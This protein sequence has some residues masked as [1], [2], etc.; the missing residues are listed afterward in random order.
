MIPDAALANLV[1]VFAWVFMAIGFSTQAQN[2][3]FLSNSIQWVN[4]GDVDVSGNQMTI[5]AKVYSNNPA[6]VN[7][8]SKHTDP[9]NANYL[10]RMG[11]FEV[12]TTNGFVAVG[13]TVPVSTNNCYHLAAT[14]DGSF[15]RYYVNGCETAAVPWSGNLLNNNLATAIGNM[16][17]CQCEQ[18]YGY[19]DE[20][21]IWN[22]ARTQTEIES[23]MDNLPNPTLQPGLRAYYSFEGNYVNLQGNAAFNGTPVGAVS[24]AINP[25]CPLT[26]A[27]FAVNANASNVV[28]GTGGSITIT[29]TGG[30]PPYTYSIDGVNFQGNPVFSNLPGGTYTATARSANGCVR[31]MQVIIA[32]PGPIVINGATTDVACNGAAIGTIN[33][34]VSGGTAPYTPVWNSPLASGLN[35][36]GLSA[37]AYNVTITDAQGC[38]Q[39]QSFTINQPGPLSTVLANVQQITCFGLSDGAATA[40][41]AGGTLPYSYLWTN[42]ESTATATALSV[43]THSATITDGN[44]CTVNSSNITISQPLPIQPTVSINQ[45]VSCNGLSDGSATVSATGGGLPYTFLWPNGITTATNTTLA[46]GNGTVTVNDANNC[47]ATAAYTIQEPSALSASISVIS[48]VSCNGGSDAVANASA[49]GGI[50]PY[51]FTWS[52][53]FVGQNVSNLSEGINDVSVTDDNGCVA[54]ASTTITEPP[55]LTATIVAISDVSCNGLADG[56]ADVTVNGGTAPYFYVWNNGEQTQQNSTLSAG[57]ITVSVSDINGC[58]ITALGTM[59]E[60]SGLVVNVIVDQNVSCVGLSDGQATA[61]ETGGV[62][63]YSFTWSNGETVSNATQLNAGTHSVLLTDGNGCSVTSAPFIISEPAALT[64]AIQSVS[65]VTCNGLSDGTATMVINGGTGPYQIAWPDGQSSTTGINLSAGNYTVNITDAN[66]CVTSLSV[67]I[68]EPLPMSAT[69]QWLSDISCFGEIDGR[70][71]VTVTGGTPPFTFMWSNGENVQ[72]ATELPSGN[73][74][75]VVFDSYLCNVASNTINIIEPPQL[76]VTTSVLNDASCFGF[77]DGNADATPTGGTP[78]Y[79]FDWSNGSTTNLAD[80]V[81]SGTYTVTVTDNNSCTATADVTIASPPEIDFTV[82]ADATMCI[83]EVLTL[84]ATP[85]P[86][87][88]PLSFNWSNGFTGASQQVSPIVSTTYTV[89]AQNGI[90]TS[91]PTDI[92]ITV[93]PPISVQASS[94]VSVCVGESAE[95]SASASGGSGNLTYT[96]DTNL[97]TGQGP[98]TVAP[99]TTSTYTVTVTDDCGTPAQTAQITVTVNPLPEIDYNADSPN[100]CVPHAVQIQNASTIASG[101]IV[102]HEWN[103]GTQTSADENPQFVFNQAG[104]FDL[105]VT[106]TSDAGCQSTETYVGVVNSYPNPVAAFSV[107]LSVVDIL[108]PTVAVSNQSVGAVNYSWMAETI[109]STEFEPAFSF[110]DT[111]LHTIYLTVSTENGCEDQSSVT[112][113]VEPSFAFY[114][115]DAFTV[116]QDF[117]NEVFSPKFIG[118]KEYEMRIFNRWGNEVYRTRDINKGWN[119]KLNGEGALL[120]QDYYVYDVKLLLFNGVPKYYNGKVLL[121]R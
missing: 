34:T 32:D 107:D 86:G 4:C 78:P 80:N 93:N 42:G 89:T 101:S 70:A 82:S 113:K 87:Q 65:N 39:S 54:N 91:L 68:T 8:V 51:T 108:S 43:G 104:T 74:S 60:P 7:I 81:I 46:A 33:L 29:T 95:I 20:V 72:T 115:P 64:A 99:Q 27:L 9:S 71:T 117:M 90:C 77:D 114:A 66:A 76:Q 92:N 120:K 73:A 15:V 55:V 56:V 26:T 21:R 25:T 111:G 38:T 88:P 96:W 112:I 57:N 11:S 13:S 105:T 106:A 5:E 41:P 85:A 53:G 35:P 119:G 110:Q 58:S 59:M 37:G 3:L 31:S 14:Y 97:P 30:L 1:R 109:T 116:N 45:D 2:S 102:N 83:G 44:G 52:N 98:H 69:A 24:T 12:T 62:A 84:D 17:N 79:A 121:V 100:G 94:D 18:F 23:N 28:C 75:V 16:S 10:L 103:L 49:L 36:T 48:N 6:S 67:T 19:I 118:V 40:I 61:T 22:V 63:P 47:S 50:P